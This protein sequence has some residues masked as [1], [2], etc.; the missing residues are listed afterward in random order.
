[1]I[2]LDKKIEIEKINKVFQITNI[3]YFEIFSKNKKIEI[4]QIVEFFIG[5]DKK[6]FTCPKSRLILTFSSN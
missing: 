6:K 3:K 4:S 1:M 2:C 5:Y